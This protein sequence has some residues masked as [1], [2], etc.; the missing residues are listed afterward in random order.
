MNNMLSLKAA[1]DRTLGWCHGNSMRY[2]VATIAA[3]APVAKEEKNRSKSIAIV[4]DASGSMSGEKLQRAKQAALG[5]AELMCD[6]DYLTVVSFASDVIV[7]INKSIMNTKNRLAVGNAINALETRG[8]TN[9]SE[10]W[11]TAAECIASLAEE[12]I[13]SRIIL[14][15]D[16][17]A[18]AGVQDPRELAR[19]AA[20]LASRGISTS[21]VGIGDDYELSILESIAENGGGRLHD[22]EFASEIVDALLGEL[23]EIAEIAA[24]KVSLTLNAPPN[25]KATLVGSST[26]KL[27]AGEI[28]VF[29]GSIIGSRTR[30]II[31]RIELPAGAIDEQIALKLLLRGTD[32]SGHVTET[33]AE[34]VFTL[35]TGNN[36][37]R[38][39]RDQTVAMKVAQAWQATVV[40]EAAEM[41]RRGERRQV[42]HY[43][44]QEL[45]HLGRYVE[46][47]PE[48]ELLIQELSLILQK[49]EHTWDE[50]T[51]KEMQY[52][53]FRYQKNASDYRK[54]QTP[55][56]WFDRLSRNETKPASPNSNPRI[57]YCKRPKIKKSWLNQGIFLQIHLKH[58][59][60]TFSLPHDDL[61][62][63]VRDNKDALNSPSWKI[64]GEYHWPPKTVP[65]DMLTFLKQHEIST[66]K[67]IT[68]APSVGPTGVKIGY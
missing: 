53:S 36:N 67:N 54:R 6:A 61:W 31:F 62:A 57:E 48:T 46:G 7:H 32:L 18:N 26:T 38:Q 24:Q 15:S 14:L 1:C 12:K 30:T 17:K 64:R 2:V 27:S 40:R 28:S 13:V 4:I 41:N 44:E 3:D 43:I 47:L 9:L 19:I 55:E 23:S 37:N 8:N 10:G 21:A 5:V 56:S 39:T 65:A 33:G 16:G 63:W 58:S 60:Q 52:N 29:I 49:A 35:A 42:K 68:P 50:R 20:E 59:K 11:L 34:V 51:R 45:R 22:A 25:V 66:S